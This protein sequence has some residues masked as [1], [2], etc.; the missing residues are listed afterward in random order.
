M[1]ELSVLRSTSATTSM[2][3]GILQI[4]LAMLIIPAIDV[5]AKT[6]GR[7][8][9]PIQITFFR[10]FMQICLLLPLV[11]YNRLWTIPPGTLAI[12]C[13]RGVTLVIATFCFFWAIQHLPLAEAI[14][15]FFVQPLI[16]TGL[17][18]LILG[19]TIRMRRI[20]AIIFGLIG[21]M[22][23]L[24]PSFVI[25]GWPALLPLVS[26]VSM[27]F[28]MIFTSRISKVAHPFQMQFV[29]GLV[30]VIMLGIVMILG[31]FADIPGTAFLTPDSHHFKWIVGMGIASTIGHMLI[32]FSTQN[33]P[34][35]VLAPFQYVEIVTAALF[36]YLFFNDTPADTT[37]V[38]TFIIIASGVYLFHRERVVARKMAKED[39]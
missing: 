34:A 1:P 2:S 17:S 15:I 33:A 36:G 20:F 27:A 8:F 7:S 3:K 28:Y 18:V 37:F 11:I 35:S 13:M 5:C 26:A 9:D 25:F 21:A 14:A 19:E 4:C 6:L 10:F 38:G 31:Q 12:Q 22:M 30:A 32:V 39:G 24:Q 16:L 23:V 29:V